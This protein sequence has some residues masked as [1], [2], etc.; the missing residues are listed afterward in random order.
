VQLC[1]LTAVQQGNGG[2]QTLQLR[3][4]SKCRRR[5]Q[6]GRLAVL[7]PALELETCTAVHSGLVSMPL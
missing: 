2:P 6:D 5:S 1:K 7:K 3:C 4:D